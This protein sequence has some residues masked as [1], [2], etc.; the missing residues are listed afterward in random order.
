MVSRRAPD[1]PPQPRATAPGALL[2]R[3][4]VGRAES[5]PGAPERS[6]GAGRDMRGP[7]ADPRAGTLA[8]PSDLID[9]AHLVTAYYTLEPDPDDVDQQVA[10]G[11]SGH[12]GQQPQ[13]RVQRGAHR[14]DDAGDL[15]LPQRAGVRRSA[16]PR[17]RHPRPERAG[18][19]DRDRGAGRQRR[20]GAGRR[21]ATP[22]RRPRRSRT[23]SSAPTA[24]VRPA[25]ASPTASSSPRAT[26]RPATA[27]SSTTR[28]TVAR[29]T[30]TRRP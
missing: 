23:R 16:V 19:G 22:T 9:V 21:R 4:F 28:R 7:M 10:F 5:R 26:T 24:A 8:Q 27:A 25:A 11:T 17:P 29:P 6:T 18:V 13:H 2:D 1:G 20:D 15:R 14:R 3:T 12:R 30:P